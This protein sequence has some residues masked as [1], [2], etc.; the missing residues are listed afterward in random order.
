VVWI[1]IERREHR[2]QRGL[3]GAANHARV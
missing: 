1:A 3:S 2:L